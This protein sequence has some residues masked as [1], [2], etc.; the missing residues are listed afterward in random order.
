MILKSRLLTWSP[1][2]QHNMKNFIVFLGLFMGLAS[3][4]NI[5]EF[6]EKFHE[7]FAN[8]EDEA[9]AAEALAEH[10]AQINKQHED[11]IQGKANFDEGNYSNTNI[12]FTFILPVG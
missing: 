7:D 9:K 1:K 2:S 10:E 11:F 5:K 6:E 4:M 3:A 12:V 8:P